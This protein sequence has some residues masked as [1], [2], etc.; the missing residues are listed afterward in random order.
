MAIPFRCIVLT[1]SVLNTSRR[2]A[3][4]TKRQQM[5]TNLQLSD[6]IEQTETD[7]AF[8]SSNIPPGIEIKYWT[9]QDDLSENHRKIVENFRFDGGFWK[10][11]EIERAA[12]LDSPKNEFHGKFK[13]LKE[14]LDTFLRMDKSVKGIILTRNEANRLEVEKYL[15]LNFAQISNSKQV[16]AMTSKKLMEI[17]DFSNV[18]F[19]ICMDRESIFNVKRYQGAYLA[20]LHRDFEKLRREDG[21]I[22][23]EDFKSTA[24]SSSKPQ[25]VGALERYEFKFEK[26]R[27]KINALKMPVEY[28]LPTSSSSSEKPSSST[29]QI[30]KNHPKNPESNTTI[31]MSTKEHQELISRIKNIDFS[32][33]RQKNRRMIFGEMNEDLICWN[34]DAQYLGDLKSSKKTLKMVEYLRNE[35]VERSCKVKQLFEYTN[36]ISNPRHI[37]NLDKLLQKIDQLLLPK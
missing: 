8:R 35:K 22:I 13:F 36:E 28:F 21:R 15:A 1:T 34:Q 18:T 23:V 16:L 30:S 17:V 25:K 3:V 19:I 11:P 37:S 5:I 29:N 9:T 7:H 27:L 26:S 33:Y 20:I 12:L 31:L 2:T 32:K 6:W 24:S 10:A 14:I 4:I